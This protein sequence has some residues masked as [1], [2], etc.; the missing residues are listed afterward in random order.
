LWSLHYWRLLKFLSRNEIPYMIVN[1]DDLVDHTE[2]VMRQVA[3][4]IGIEITAEQINE[5]RSFTDER[6]RH[7]IRN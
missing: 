5:G 4:F 7:H 6:L 1:Y 2:T 3:S